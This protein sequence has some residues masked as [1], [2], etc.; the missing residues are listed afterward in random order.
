[1]PSNPA[2][3]GDAIGYFDRFGVHNQYYVPQVG[4]SAEVRYR[5]CFLQATGKLGLGLLH[6]EGKTAGGTTLRLADGTVNSVGGGVL[7][8]GAGAVEGD[9]LA[10]LSELALTA[11]YEVASWCRLSVG[12]DFLFASQVVRAGRLLAGVNS[13]QVPQLPSYDPALSGTH[14]MPPLRSDSFWAQGLAAGLEFRY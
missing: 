3:L 9:R 4:V 5:R 1:V 2:P 13:T 7:V 11:G 10:V 14:L 8:P 6:E 12:Y